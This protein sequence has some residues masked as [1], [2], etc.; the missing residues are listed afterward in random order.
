[1]TS[2]HEHYMWR[3]IDLAYRAESRAVGLNPR[4]G[5]LLVHQGRIIGEGYHQ[6]MGEAHA[7]VHCLESVAESDRPLIPQSTL[8]VTLEPCAHQGRT[9]SCANRLVAEH[10]GRVVVG[11]PDPN[12]LVAGKG[13]AILREAGIPVEMG[14]LSEACEELTKVFLTNQRLHRPYILLKWAESAD[15]YIDTLRHSAE[16]RPV[17][18]STP[19]T[20]LLAHRLRSQYSAILVGAETLRLDR[21]ALTNRRW[22]PSPYSP[23]PILLSSG[24]TAPDG[25]LRL[26]ELTPESLSTLL[27][28]HHIASLMV[29]G[30]ARV[31]Q[32][33]IDQGLWDEARVER[34]PLLIHEG[35]PAPHL[36]EQATALSSHRFA[37]NT[38]TTYTP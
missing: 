36:S 4:V 21:P 16:E 6:R 38:I 5:A 17:L 24:T 29:E 30:G 10:V 7:E 26:S 23:Q 1:M 15:G 19:Y 28:K 8:Y 33:F 27:E 12:P 2:S 34:S 18:L 11:I 31:L 20:Q 14:C 25:W 13:V 37:N 35:V 32:S 9:P 22:L 3:A